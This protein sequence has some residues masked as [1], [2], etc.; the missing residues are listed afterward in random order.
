[1][2]QRNQMHSMGQGFS[3]VQM[4]ENGAMFSRN[5]PSNFSISLI[6]KNA[7]RQWFL[8]CVPNNFGNSRQATTIH[9]ETLSGEGGIL[10]LLESRQVTHFNLCLV[11]GFN[12]IHISLWIDHMIATRSSRN[13][14]YHCCCITLILRLSL[15]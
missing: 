13:R 3:Q 8:F 9:V 6:A 4:Q 1:M 15:G 11:P 12:L 2:H 7:A 5:H 14:W 10:L